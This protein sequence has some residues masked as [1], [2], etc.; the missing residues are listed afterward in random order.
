MK[1][2]VVIIG[3]SSGIGRALAE[4]YASG[5]CK[6]GIAARREEALKE[7]ASAFPHT[8]VY[9]VADVTKESSSIVLAELIEETGGAD[10]IIFCS[11]AG[12]Y[13]ETL[14]FENEHHTTDVWGIKRNVI[15]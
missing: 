8:I 11:G 14:N 7:V 2:R 1:K 9:R 15:V 4:Y 10:L 3:A 12:R 13:S 5:G 6:V